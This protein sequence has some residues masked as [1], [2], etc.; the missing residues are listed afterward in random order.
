MATQ[1]RPT[2]VWLRDE[3]RLHDNAL[4]A[5]AAKRGGPVVPVHCLDPRVVGAAAT[6]DHGS[7]KTGPR[8]AKFLLESLA[9]LRSSLAGAGSGAAAAR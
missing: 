9:D 3:L 7:G 6:S 5:E 2:I 8:R 1:K 4:L